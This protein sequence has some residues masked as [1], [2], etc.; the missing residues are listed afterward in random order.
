MR[1]DP[2]SAFTS[3]S[4]RRGSGILVQELL[5]K[6]EAG[7]AEQ[8]HLVL[9]APPGHATPCGG[10]RVITRC[11][12]ASISKGFEKKLAPQRSASSRSLGSG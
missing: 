7:G 6:D 4:L 2:M 5:R 8:A 11:T 9:L 3:V 12:S 10:A 1:T